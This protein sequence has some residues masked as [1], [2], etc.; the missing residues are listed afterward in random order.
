MKAWAEKIGHG[1]LLAA[2]GTAAAFATGG[3][4]TVA[5]AAKVAA[6]VFAAYMAKPARPGKARP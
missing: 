3:V 6:G 2:V 5:A 4:A 1:L